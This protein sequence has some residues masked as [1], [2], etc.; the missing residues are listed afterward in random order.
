MPP[1]ER[2]PGVGL[3]AWCDVEVPND[4]DNRVSPAQSREQ[5]RQA[6]VLTIGVDLVVGPFEFHADGKIV[7]ALARQLEAPACQA[8]FAQGTSWINSPL[9]RTRK[10]ADTFRSRRVS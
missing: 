7:A 6:R 2:R 3:A 1:V 4:I 5:F 9:R 8:R 10:C